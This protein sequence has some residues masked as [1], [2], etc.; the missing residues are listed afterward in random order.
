MSLSDA[1]V[2]FDRLSAHPHA[3]VIESD[4]A[5]T[6]EL[7]LDSLDTTDRHARLALGLFADSHLGRGIG[8]RAIAQALDHAFGP[9]GLHRV[10]LRVLAFNTRAIRCYTACG[11]R[12]EGTL[13]ENAWIDGA[14][15]DDLIMGLLAHDPRP[16]P[17]TFD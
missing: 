8:R 10:D 5:L 12:H 11:F 9:L 1:Q 16:H 14:W 6:G 2:W 7:R 4:G 3:W 15:H 17:S 13:R